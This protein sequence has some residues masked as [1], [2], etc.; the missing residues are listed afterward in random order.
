[1]RVPST[2][3]ERVHHRQRR[4][5]GRR[6]GQRLHHRPAT[7]TGDLWVPR[8]SSGLCDLR[9]RVL[10]DHAT[11][12]STPVDDQVAG[13]RRRCG[14]PSGRRLAEGAVRPVRVVVIYEDYSKASLKKYRPTAARNELRN[15]LS[16]RR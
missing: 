2:R 13:R 16:G 9:I 12:S 1:M 4:E 15:V 5:R 10:V 6:E 8:M 11:K 7:D 14:S 3:G